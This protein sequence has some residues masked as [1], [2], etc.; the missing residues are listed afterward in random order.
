[1]SDYR[2]REGDTIEATLKGVV[3]WVS[4]ATPDLF[5]LA[6]ADDEFTFY[7]STDIESVKVLSMRVEFVPGDVVRHKASGREFIVGVDGCLCK[8]NYQWYPLA[9]PWTSE[10]YDLVSRPEQT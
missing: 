9:H 4:E 10:H 6:T 2:P 1:M 3:A 8:E 7:A 5:T